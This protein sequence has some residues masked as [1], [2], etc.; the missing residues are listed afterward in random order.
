MNRILMERMGAACSGGSR[1]RM[2]G[3][4]VW[5]GCASWSRMTIR[6]SANDW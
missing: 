6:R 4:Y 5:L 2:M 3:V 1:K